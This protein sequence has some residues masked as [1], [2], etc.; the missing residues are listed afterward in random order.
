MQL[1]LPTVFKIFRLVHVKNGGH[2]DS[3]NVE[4]V[5]SMLTL[6]FEINSQKKT[7]TKAKFGPFTTLNFTDFAVFFTSNIF[8]HL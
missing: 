7:K 3:A 2:S 8:P 1:G 6:I 4:E 5:S